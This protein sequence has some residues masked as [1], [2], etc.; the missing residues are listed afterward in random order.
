MGRLATVE[1]QRGGG[2][3]RLAGEEGSEKE[4]GGGEGKKRNG[5]FVK[6]IARILEHFNYRDIT[7]GHVY[8]AKTT[9]VSVSSFPLE[10]GV[11]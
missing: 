5:V 3:S 10:K 6:N 2:G 8:T 1:A 9:F 11:R 4:R 7:F